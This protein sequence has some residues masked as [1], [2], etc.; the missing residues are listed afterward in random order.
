MA[1]QATV[2]KERPQ[3][4]PNLEAMQLV[5]AQRR[6]SELKSPQDLGTT[7]RTKALEA[8][9]LETLASGQSITASAWTIGVHRVTAARWRR[10]SEATKQEDG[11][12]KDDFCVRWDEAL[13]ASV[14]RLEDEARRR[15][16]KGYERP[17]YQGGVMV[18]TTTEY[19]DTLMQILMKGNRPQK[20]NTERHELS[21]PGGGPMA[22]AME[23]EFID[24]KGKK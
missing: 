6:R 20:Y 13:E 4:V 23:I 22:H 7:R 11:T 15:A 8:L 1:K 2:K 10:E 12:F 21:G 16:E 24:S 19:S 14:D 17:V 3:P 18:G 9:F 5:E